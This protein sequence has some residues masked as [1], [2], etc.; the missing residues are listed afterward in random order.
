MNERTPRQ[1]P[2]PAQSAEQS[3]TPWDLP[4]VSA[5]LNTEA[6]PLTDRLAGPGQTFQLAEDIALTLFPERQMLRFSSPLA[7][8]VL[9]PVTSL[10]PQDENVRVESRDVHHQAVARF[11]PQGGVIFTLQPN[12]AVIA[13]ES[14]IVE[15]APVEQSVPLIETTPSAD[16]EAAPAMSAPAEKEPTAA[17]SGS[18]PAATAEDER[19]ERLVFT[20]RIGRVPELKTTAKGRKLVRI[21]LAVHEGEATSW[22]TIVFFD[23]LAERAATTLA[24]GELI[25]VVGYKHVREVPTKRGIKQQELIFAAALHGSKKDSPS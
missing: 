5:S 16:N 21:P 3:P 23:E 15:E 9:A 19:G 24:K 6:R 2:T 1:R 11:D 17:P 25:S 20:G 8:L 10:L 18:T 22:H 14:V 13:A 7:E 4:A 12:E